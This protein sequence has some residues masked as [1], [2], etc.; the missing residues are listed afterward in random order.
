MKKRK[1][2]VVDLDETLFDS[3][4]A[5]SKNNIEAVNKCVDLNHIVIIATSRPLRT[6][7]KRLPRELKT[8]YLVICNGARIVKN[9]NIINRNEM[10]SEIV[11]QAVTNLISYGFM[12]AIE[13]NDCIFTDS[14]KIPGFESHFFP[15]NEYQ[16]VD[17]CKVMA[18]RS[19][20]ISEEEVKRIVPSELT[21]ITTDNGTLLQISSKSCTKGTACEK[22]FEFEN[23]DRTMTYAFGDDNNDISI[24]E[25]VAF[26]IAMENANKELKDIACYITESNENSGVAKGID[27]FILP[28]ANI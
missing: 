22:I 14:E 19:G 16:D 25:K 24:F 5:V 9:G 17:A 23:I 27:K 10:K 12:P 8:S 13:A 18:Y 20:R 7:L 2:I 11:R 1:A 6:V 4:K 26:G 15:L 28:E 21:S 3:Q